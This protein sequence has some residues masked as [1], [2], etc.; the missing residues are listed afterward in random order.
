[1]TPVQQ[2]LYDAIAARDAAAAKYSQ[3]RAR[4]EREMHA[5]GDIIA[6]RAA[7]RD[8]YRSAAGLAASG[9]AHDASDVEEKRLALR[10]ADGDLDELKLRREGL[11]EIVCTAEAALQ[12][13]E[14]LVALTA[15]RVAQ[16]RAS[17]V[18]ERAVRLATE[19]GSLV[20]HHR[21]LARYAA[22][23]ETKA[24]GYMADPIGGASGEAT[25]FSRAIA[26]ALEGP[27][28]AAVTTGD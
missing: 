9:D 5:E 14:N 1:M 18:R 26:T 23:H 13:S 4:L 17:D 15:S 2:A 19:L 27:E 11:T 24:R 8:A 12:R 3:L 10:A 21:Q 28:P 7:A 20:I 25:D 22:H 6:Q 16:E